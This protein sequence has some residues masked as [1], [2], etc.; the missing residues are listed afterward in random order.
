MNDEE[1]EILID[2][3]FSTGVIEVEC[4]ICGI[5]INS[6]FDTTRAWCIQCDEEVEVR[7]ILYELGLL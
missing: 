4:L 5:S 6:G 7:N 2:D 1:L 3:A